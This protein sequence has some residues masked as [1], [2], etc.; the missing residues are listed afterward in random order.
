MGWTHDYRDV[1]RDHRDT[2]ATGRSAPT[3]GLHRQGQLLPIPRILGRRAR[4]VSA[5]LRHSARS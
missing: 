5:R 3:A 4:W 1:S 2:T